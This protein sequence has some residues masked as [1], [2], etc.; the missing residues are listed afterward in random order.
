SSRGQFGRLMSGCGVALLSRV[1]LRA[2][3]SSMLQGA[4]PPATESLKI[5]AGR[6]IEILERH[7]ES[8]Y[9]TGA[10]ALLG[11]GLHAEVVTVGESS[12]ET[13]GRMRRGRPF[14]ITPMEPAHNPGGTPD[15]GQ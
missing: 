14:R 1:P 12:R 5:H 2:G 7:I 13:A 10:V 11:R 6:V 9:M 15:A 4:T 3:T 8:G